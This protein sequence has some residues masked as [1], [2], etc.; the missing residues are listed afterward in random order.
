MSQ[1]ETM[2][3]FDREAERMAA[4]LELEAA[5]QGT[6]HA[7]DALDVLDGDVR[8]VTPSS[9]PGLSLEQI[10]DVWHS[11]PA[12]QA[13]ATALA[14][15]REVTDT[16]DGGEALVKYYTSSREGLDALFQKVA[17]EVEA[18][19]A[20]YVAEFE[21][22]EEAIR[23]MEATAVEDLQGWSEFDEQVRQ[24]Q[25]ETM[26][27]EAGSQALVDTARYLDEFGPGSEIEVEVATALL[28]EG[29]VD[30]T[31]DALRHARNVLEHAE[32]V[33]AEKRA[34]VFE[35]LDDPTGEEVAQGV[36]KQDKVNSMSPEEIDEVLQIAGINVVVPAPA[37]YVDDP[38]LGRATDDDVQDVLDE[39][40]GSDRDRELIA[41]ADDRHNEPE[42]DRVA[43]VAERERLQQV[44]VDDEEMRELLGDDFVDEAA[45]S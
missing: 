12:A 10:Q 24:E 25:H 42:E 6:E 26:V 19:L 9:I 4:A 1:T 22:P 43:R 23:E 15:L 40:L 37:E 5:T 17:R 7:V 28:A 44:S 31:Y 16:S 41:Q 36:T 45:G 35:L 32:Q 39:V 29:A 18:E 2:S 20:M 34:V 8:I 30:N 11:G 13:P 3:E 27:E 38:V 14:K 21:T 33:V